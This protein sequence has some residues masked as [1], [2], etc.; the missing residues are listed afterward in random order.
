MPS[1][2]ESSIFKS[3]L[4]FQAPLLTTAHKLVGAA[5]LLGFLFAVAHP[6]TI[7]VTLLSVG[8]DWGTADWSTDLAGYL[9]GVGVAFLCQNAS[10]VP[11]A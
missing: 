2:F 8:A 10:N 7:L 5:A 6:I 4:V 11:S 1:C 9:A 3:I